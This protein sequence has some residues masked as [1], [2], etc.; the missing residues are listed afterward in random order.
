MLKAE[1][2]RIDLHHKPYVKIRNYSDEKIIKIHRYKYER[3][4]SILAFYKR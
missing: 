4:I 1:T 2:E 3:Q